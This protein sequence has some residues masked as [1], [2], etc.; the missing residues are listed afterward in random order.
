MTVLN[1]SAIHHEADRGMISP[2]NPLHVQPCSI[3]LTLGNKMLIE[4]L[5]QNSNGWVEVDITK[6]YQLK[7]GQFV[8]CSTAEKVTLP[9]DIAGQLML[10]SSAARKGF[11][12]CLA[13]FVDSGWSGELTLELRNNLQ[14]NFLE[15]QA[16]MRLMQLVCYKLN[17]PSMANYAVTG[18]YK[19]QAGP[20]PSNNN[21]QPI[22]AD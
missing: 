19:N 10:R 21:L 13:G 3:D 4:S 20:T 1:D 16:G 7:P 8:L 6:P 2:Y 9:D 11:D 12:H 22:V 15:I 14:L 18:K 5:D 17:F